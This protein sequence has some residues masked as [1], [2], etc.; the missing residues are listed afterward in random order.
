MEGRKEGCKQGSQEPRKHGQK[1][2]GRNNVTK[3]GPQGR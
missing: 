2:A 3:K 1:K